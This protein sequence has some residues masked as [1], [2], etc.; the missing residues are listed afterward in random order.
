[1]G[2]RFCK[3]VLDVVG[4]VEA[5]EEMSTPA[6]VDTVA[7]PGQIGELDAAVCK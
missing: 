6:C 5:I 2:I 4:Q 3:S 7:V 1:M